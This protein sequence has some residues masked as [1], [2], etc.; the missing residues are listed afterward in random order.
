MTTAVLVLRTFYQAR[1]DFEAVAEGTTTSPSMMAELA[2]IGNVSSHR[3]LDGSSPWNH[4]EQRSSWVH[5]NESNIPTSLVASIKRIT[6]RRKSNRRLA[7]RGF[8]MNQ[9]IEPSDECPHCRFPLEILS[10]KI[11]L[12][13]TAMVYACMNCAMARTENPKQQLA[14]ASFRRVAGDRGKV[15]SAFF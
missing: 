13:G 12:R 6:R 9:A 4:Q 7:S 3:S 2:L 11:G 14:W 5:D 10:V 15:R 1:A 8:R